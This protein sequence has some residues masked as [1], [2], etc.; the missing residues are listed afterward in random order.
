MSQEPS[1]TDLI[2]RARDF[3]IACHQRIDHGRKYNQQ[4]YAVHLQAVALRVASVTEDAETIAAAWLHDLVEDT[5]T[6]IRQVE[7][8]FGPGVAALVRDL[9]DVSRSSDGNRAVRKAID[10]A[11]TAA[12]SPRANSSA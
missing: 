10:R 7:D 11:H 3:A 9:T 6:T 2:Q 12:A 5:A 8:D 1:P 4:P